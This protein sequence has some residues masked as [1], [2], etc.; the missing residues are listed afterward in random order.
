MIGSYAVLVVVGVEDVFVWVLP[1]L[2]SPVFGV[3]IKALIRAL[4][5]AFLFTFTS[6]FYGC[7]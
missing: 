3:G 1:V 6:K 5:F 4:L 2:V 7:L